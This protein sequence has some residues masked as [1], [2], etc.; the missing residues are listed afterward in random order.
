MTAVPNH[1]NAV[2]IQ[3]VAFLYYHSA[4]RYSVPTCSGFQIVVDSISVVG[5]LKEE[6]AHN[7]AA[8]LGDLVFLAVLTSHCFAESLGRTVG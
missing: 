7:L 4:D 2:Q 8:D 5:V 6:V 3:M 1:L